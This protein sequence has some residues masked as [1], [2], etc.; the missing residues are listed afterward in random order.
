MNVESATKIVDIP[1]EFAEAQALVAVLRA[2]LARTRHMQL[3]LARFPMRTVTTHGG[4]P[5]LEMRI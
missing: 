4:S 3:R 5:E 2:K 1:K